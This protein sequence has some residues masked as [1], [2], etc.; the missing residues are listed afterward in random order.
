MLQF[1]ELLPKKRVLS[2]FLA[3]VMVL[4]IL[5]VTVA[6]AATVNTGVTGLSAESTGAASWSS[7]NGTI[8]GSV[9]AKATTSCGSTSY[10][11]QNGTLTFT[12][13]SGGLRM[14]SFD[15]S[16]GVN[17]GSITIDGTAVTAGGGFSKKLEAGETVAVVLTSNDSNDTATTISISNMK[18][19]EEKNVTVTFKAPVNGS[20]TVDGAAI[21]VDTEKTIKTTDIVALAATPASNYKLFGWFNVTT[22]ECLATAASA[23]LTFSEN[24]TVEPRFVS[25]STPVFKTGDKLFTDLNE[26]I[27]YAQSSGSATIVLIANGTLP[28]GNYTIPSGK[29][30]LMPMDAGYSVVREE[31]TVIY[32]SHS[33]PSAYSLLTMANGANITV[34]NGGELC[35]AGNLCSTGQL[36]GWNGCTTGPGGRIKMNSGSTIKVQSG[37]KLYAWGYIYGSGS[38]EVQSGGTVYEAFQIKDWRGGTATSNCYSYTFIISQ[39]YIQ[40]IEVPM[41][42]YAGCTEKLWSSA[43]ASSSAYPMGATFVGS[44]GMF[45]I[46]SGYLI[47]DYIES[48]DRLQIDA[49]GDVSVTTMQLTGLPMI[50]SISTADYELP[51]TSNITLN[52]HSGS[53]S[54]QQNIK[55]LPAV[56][57]NVDEGA[58]MQVN[59]GKKI[60]VYD[61]D[62][63]GNFT[64]SAR[65]YVIGYSVAN[66][67]TAKRNASSL[68]DAKVNLNGTATV[69]GNVYTSLG[70]GNITSSTGS[71]SFTFAT[72]PGTNDATIYEM[73]GNSTKTAVTFNPVRLHNGANR[74][75]GVEEYRATAG[76]AA[77]SVFFYCKALD[78]WLKNGETLA[79]VSF[80]GN[81]PAGKTVSG[82]MN[83]FTIT[84]DKTSF[85]AAATLDDLKV[86]LPANAYSVDGYQFTGWNTAADGTG[87]SY[88]AADAVFFTSN[89]TLY[90]QWEELGTLANGYYLIGTRNDWDMNALDSSLMFELNP[91]SNDNEWMLTLSLTENEQFKVIKVDNGNVTWYPSADNSNYTVDAGHAGQTK[92]VFFRP[93]YNGGSDWWYNTIYVPVNVYT[94]T[95]KN[96]DG[97]VID[98]T[99]V[100]HGTVP[101]HADP[102]KE[103]NAQYSY[104]FTGWNPTPVAAVADAEYTATFSQTTNKYNITWKNDDGSV[105]ETTQV[106]YGTV[107]TH[108]APE[109][110]NTAQ[111]TYTFI[112]WEPTPVPVTG[113]AEYTATFQET[114]NEYEIIFQNYDGT[115]LQKTNVEYGTMPSYLGTEPV[116]PSTAEFSYSFNGWTPELTTVTGPATYTA[117]YE[118]TKNSYYITWKNWNGDTFYTELLEYGKTPVFNGNEPTKDSDT[119]HDYVFAGWTPEIVAVT[120]NAEYTAVFTATPRMYDIIWVVEGQE[121]VHSSW[122]YGSTPVYMVNGEP[123]TPTKASDE[124]YS[125]TFAGWDPE[126]HSV[127]GEETYIATFTATTRTYTVT[128]NVE[129]VITQETYSYGDIPVYKVNGEPATP[130]KA[131]TAQYYYNFTGWAPQIDMVTA[132]VTYVA[133]FEQITQSYPVIFEDEEGNE[134]CV[135]LYDYGE[136]PVY[137]G[138]EINDYD[139]DYYN[140]YFIGWKNK[141]TEVLYSDALPAVTGETRY[142]VTWQKSLK[143]GYYVI[144]PDWVVEDIDPTMKFVENPA[145]EGEYML[146]DVVLSEGDTMKVVEVYNGAIC[147]WYPDGYDNEYAVE[148]DYAN[149]NVTIYLRP[150]GANV[151]NSYWQHFG[152]YIF[153]AK[154]SYV[155]KF[156]N[157]DN[158]ELETLE[159]NYNEIPTCS[160]TPT[161]ASTVEKDFTFA[162]WRDAEGTQYPVGTDL[163]AVI[164]DVT[165][166]AY[167]T[168]TARVYTI[169]FVLNPNNGEVFLDETFTG[170]ME[171]AYGTEIT[172]WPIAYREG[173]VF[174]GW[175]LGTKTIYNDGMPYT[176][177]GD[178]TF[179]GVFT[180]TTYTVVWKNWDG[181]IL[182]TDEDVPYGDM[183]NFDGDEPVRDADETHV[184]SFAGW[185]PEITAVTED[186]EYTATYDEATRYY[187][188]TWI[189]EGVNTETSWEYGQTPSFGSTPT[190]EADAQYTYS[191]SHWT[192]DVVAVTQDASY[193]A[194]FSSTLNKYNIRFFNEDGELLYEDLVEYGTVPVYGGETPTKEG[195]EQYSYEF[196]GWE[197]ELHEVNG[198]QDYY[199]TFTNITNTYTVTW[200]NYDGSLLYEQTDVP[201]GTMPQYPGEDIPQKPSDAQYNYIFE[202][203]TPRLAIV[204]GNVTYTATFSGSLRAYYIQ[205]VNYDGMVL[206]EGYYAYGETPSYTGDTPEKPTDEQYV[207]TFSGW[208]PEPSMVTGE[209]TYTAQFEGALRSYPITF[210]NW[211]GEELQKTDVP[212]GQLPSYNGTTPARE[213][214]AQY[215]YNWIGWEPEL[216]SV[217]GEATYQAVFEAVVNKYTVTYYNWDGTELQSEEVEYGAPVPAYVFTGPEG[218]DLTPT[219]DTTE[220]FTYSFSGWDPDPE[221]IETVTEDLAFYAQFDAA[222]NSYEIT[223]IVDDDSITQTYEYGQTPVYPNGTPA[224]P[225]TA[226]YDYVFIG[227]DKDVVPVT[228][229]EVYIAQF[230]ADLRS[231]TVTWMNGDELWH[232]D[233]VPYGQVPSEPEDLPDKTLAENEYAGEYA[234]V[235]WTPEL[236]AVTGE[237]TY[238]ATFSYSGWRLIDG[239]RYYYRNDEVMKTGWTIIENLNY[240]LD[241]ETGAAAV[242]ISMVP[243]PYGTHTGRFIFDDMGVWQQ[244]Q[245]GLYDD[246][247][248]TYWTENGE[249][250]EEAGLVRLVEDGEVHYYY[251]AT[252]ENVEENPDLEIS[253]AVKNLLPEGGKDCWIHKTNDLALPEW[254]YYFDENGI[255]LHDPDTSKNGINEDDGVLF[256]YIDGIKAYVGLFQEGGYYYYAKHTGELIHDRSYYVSKTNGLLPA[257]TYTFDSEC[258]LIF[259][260]DK[261]GIIAEDGSLWYYVN[262]VRTYVGLIEIDGD[263]YYVKSNCEVVHGRSYY[264]SWTNNLLPAGNYVF[265]D[266]G[267]LILD[268]KNG[269]YD[270]DGV[271]YYYK[272]NVKYYAGLIQ[273]GEDY[274]Y[275]N[276]SCQV[277][278][279]RTYWVS[280][281]NGLLDPGDYRFDEDGKLVLPENEKNGI[282]E[283]DGSLY[284]YEHDVRTYAG[285]IEIDGDYYY[286]KSNCEVVHGRRYYISW[287]HDLL[288]AGDYEFADDGKLILP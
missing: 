113:D 190:K 29:A 170:E 102:V 104:T 24:C 7:S 96:D 239:N 86:A 63:W 203:W 42:L 18:M 110:Q 60:Y 223:W 225:A 180:V 81:A 158:T 240:Y 159:L 249:I 181:E 5:P 167:Y 36:G 13:S 198:D 139:D 174:Q 111:Y 224:R 31:P 260:A 197:P 69:S 194:V 58:T 205:F 131:A 90:A 280:K 258:H 129:G 220:E 6:S 148:A 279:N 49:Y 77:G 136:T 256:Y 246:G 112:G 27:S 217:T 145:N 266:D 93:D 231:Y 230:R 169:Q 277:V 54:T 98:T 236:T 245:N 61:N 209:A 38:V 10:S 164:D 79:T 4:S 157:D 263:Y 273:V 222:T 41:K 22:G 55:L 78:M 52:L 265:D 183:P 232:V 32:G 35:C 95:W 120:E 89:T 127:D 28:A 65:L 150:D 193:T 123:A 160:V 92:T 44:G 88:T 47:K 214:N 200:N 192:P 187:T 94:I 64:G 185:T 124:Q 33:T 204:T 219:R 199:A 43:N 56:E 147:N 87:D 100:E 125:Y 39:Y 50:G 211:D 73:A 146:P 40:N 175:T 207:Y 218:E 276:S 182:E 126:I 278:K 178:A 268:V 250:V 254:G 121:D 16:V 137:E 269:F 3:L 208:S 283:E 19:T 51:I 243:D 163:P 253:K 48:T 144:G 153:I 215:T 151:N 184:Y 275:V 21:T 247:P 149:R 213:G 202:G 72:A 282:Y 259:D 162:G 9:A 83:S 267:K 57:F 235:A 99:D 30:L 227:W 71:G 66:G 237:Q 15:Y 74:P 45:N 186:V 76:S 128:W 244:N 67:T 234:F 228:G 85:Q 115:E 285:L 221:E 155:V 252:A 188:V 161:K 143:D 108:A 135:K 20:Y 281:D 206:Q 26:A 34:A 195:D 116:K 251:F 242:G 138:P 272:D 134:L 238:Y 68:V 133:Q 226:Q 212:Y 97:T 288:P 286:V 132:D 37:G 106:E 8:N 14:F 70:G 107:P 140:Y 233:S 156:V 12:N 189:V 119:E 59:S 168:E 62:D 172:E 11:S 229:D 46:S 262:G 196:L 122:A 142:V 114:V 264:V 177:T 141:E 191:F 91:E 201:Y 117:V 154:E 101:T 80:N 152:G 248:D 255:I 216:V 23:N 210:I 241:P 274:Y 176:V 257:G 105:I 130:S 261:N 1:L 25:S 17:G 2:L 287:T 284:Y 84:A 103:G 118:E 82:T 109:K 271:T 165:Y 53:V 171:L 270:E 166:T 75:D 179:Y 173:Y